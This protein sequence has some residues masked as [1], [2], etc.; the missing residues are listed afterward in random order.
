MIFDAN[1]ED[2]LRAIL[3][4]ENFELNNLKEN[5]E[6]TSE[7]WVIFYTNNNIYT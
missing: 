4:L 2:K 6:I 1:L 3:D 5:P 7:H